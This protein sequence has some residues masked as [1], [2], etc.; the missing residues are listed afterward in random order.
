M[1]HPSAARL[2][3][4]Q[5]GVVGFGFGHFV[6]GSDGAVEDAAV[7]IC[8]A[9]L[10]LSARRRHGGVGGWIDPGLVKGLLAAASSAKSCSNGMAAAGW[11]L[12]R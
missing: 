12:R 5:R 2:G 7:G 8:R 9:W 10:S 6:S 1:S 11:Y 4:A 3:A